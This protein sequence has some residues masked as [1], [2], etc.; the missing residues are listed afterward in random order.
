MSIADIKINTEQHI[1]DNW[2]H[3]TAKLY[4]DTQPVVGDNAVLIKFVAYDRNFA[5]L[6][7]KNTSTMM[8][9]FFY[10][11][12]TLKAIQLQDEFNKI[13]ECYSFNNT[14][15][16]EGKPVGSENLNGAMELQVNY[17]A[18]TIG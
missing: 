11:S 13:L 10:G 12:S 17:L 15:Y 7:R 18:S 9:V 14:F 4:F 3:P 1:L 6:G 16:Q 8:Q 5:G 2:T